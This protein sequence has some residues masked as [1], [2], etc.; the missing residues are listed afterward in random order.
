MYGDNPLEKLVGK[1]VVALF[2][3]DSKDRLRFALDDGTSVHCY[4][5]GDCCSSSWIEHIEGVA[6]LIGATVRA[7]ED[8]P[9]VPSENDGELKFY[10]FRIVTERGFCNLEMRNS[11]N[12]YYGGSLDSVEGSD[13]DASIQVADDF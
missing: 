8:G 13:T 1:K 9:E 5:D 4:T 7:A 11:S 6:N 3:N 2:R 10:N 12:G